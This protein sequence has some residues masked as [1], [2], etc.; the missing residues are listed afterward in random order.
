MKRV[1]AIPIIQ[2]IGIENMT[3]SEKLALLKRQNT[4]DEGSD[5]HWKCMVKDEL[6]EE[7]GKT[8]KKNVLRGVDGSLTLLYDERH[9]QIHPSTYASK[10]TVHLTK[11]DDKYLLFLGRI[12]PIKGLDLLINAWKRIYHQYFKINLVIIGD[13]N[14][15]NYKPLERRQILVKKTA[16]VSKLGGA[17][18]YIGLPMLFAT[19]SFPVIR[20][21]LILV[22]LT[23]IIS[24]LIHLITLD[25]EIDASF[26]KALPILRDKIDSHYHEECRSVLRAAAYTYVIGSLQSF[27][28]LRYIWLL[29][30]RLR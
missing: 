5:N 8:W 11:N 14:N 25:V 18:L 28:S 22:L 17:I 6:L 15:E 4:D 10:V 16:W 9:D 29:I 19:G 20:G 23:I 26:N 13:F 3:L 7:H 1:I 27:I 12:H 21:V 24:V 2:I 30:M